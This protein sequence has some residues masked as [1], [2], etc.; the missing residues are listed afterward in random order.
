MHPSIIAAL[1]SP[2]KAEV[3]FILALLAIFAHY[4]ASFEGAV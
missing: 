2:H 4:L 3:I 1:L